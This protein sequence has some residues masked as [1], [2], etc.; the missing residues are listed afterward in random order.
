MRT[1]P[2]QQTRN[3]TLRVD[4]EHTSHNELWL[5]LSTGRFLPPEYRAFFVLPQ[6]SECCYKACR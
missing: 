6:G 4:D 5:V 2:S 1:I 3:E